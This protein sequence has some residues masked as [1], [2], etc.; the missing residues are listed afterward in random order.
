MVV[1][2]EDRKAFDAKAEANWISKERIKDFHQLS[3][4]L[5]GMGMNERETRLDKQWAKEAPVATDEEIV[6]KAK[7]ICSILLDKVKSTI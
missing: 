6:K 4:A 5:D 7:Q 3:E 2:L 1:R